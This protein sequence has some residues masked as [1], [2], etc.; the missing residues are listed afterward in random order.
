MAGHAMSGLDDIHQSVALKNTVVTIMTTVSVAA[1]IVAGVVAWPA[2]LAMMAGG[3]IGGYG[4]ARLAQRL[5]PGKLR[6][7]IILV[8]VALTAYYFV[9]YYA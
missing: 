4:G 7:F 6:G 9:K 1:F 3:I 5:D 8:G 2:S